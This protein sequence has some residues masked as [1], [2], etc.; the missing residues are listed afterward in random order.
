M[1]NNDPIADWA[2]PIVCLSIFFM[3]IFYLS[4]MRII[5]ASISRIANVTKMNMKN[6][7]FDWAIRISGSIRLRNIR[8]IM[9]TRIR[10]ETIRNPPR[11]MYSLAL[12]R[13]Q[14]TWDHFGL[15]QDNLY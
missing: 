1:I 10:L 12:F 7:L 4:K 6:G 3:V 15:K 13:I 5:A 9:P 8:R 11:A 2:N 14:F